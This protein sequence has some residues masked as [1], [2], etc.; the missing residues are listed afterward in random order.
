MNKKYE[1][2]TGDIALGIEPSEGEWHDGVFTTP[3]GR[4]VMCDERDDTS[5]GKGVVYLKPLS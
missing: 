4:F 2:Y 1:Y 5:D 3:E